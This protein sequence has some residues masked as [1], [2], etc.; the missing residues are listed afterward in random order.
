MMSFSGL[1]TAVL[2]TV[3]DHESLK[4]DPKFQADICASFQQAVIDILLHKTQ[5]AVEKYAPVSVILA[6]GVAANAQLRQQLGELR[7]VLN[8]A[9]FVPPLAYSLDNAAMIGVAGYFRFMR[10]DVA[11]PLT[12]VANPNL[13]IA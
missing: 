8:V 4:D 3:R 5:Q 11:D 12:T 13:D 2:Y 10:G 9:C 1:K 6:G 7:R